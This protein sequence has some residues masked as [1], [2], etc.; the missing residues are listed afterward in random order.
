MLYLSRPAYLK[1]VRASAWYDLLL[2]APLATPWTFPLFHELASYLNHLS[3]GNPLP[4]FGA[5]Q[6]MIANMMGTVVLIW[7]LLRLV[8]PSVRLGRFDAAGRFLFA[9][10]MARALALTGAPILWLLVVPEFTWGVVQWWPIAEPGDGHARA[11]YTSGFGSVRSSS[12]D[13]ASKASRATTP[14]T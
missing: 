6:T 7:S 5:F 9:A 4:D 8:E 14:Y 12:S 2:T 13:A 3:G 11:Q 10:W 1:I